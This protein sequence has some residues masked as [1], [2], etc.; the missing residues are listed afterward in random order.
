MNVDNKPAGVCDTDPWMLTSS[1][2]KVYFLRPDSGSLNLGDVCR[3]LGNL[4]RFTGAVSQFYSVA[5]HS[6]AVGR[7]VQEHLNEH[8]WEKDSKYWNQILAGLMHDAAEAYVN[9][10]SSPLKAAI[11]GKYDWIESGIRRKLFDRYRVPHELYN[12][13][14]KWADQQMCAIE[15]YYFMPQ[16]EDWPTPLEVVGAP[17][18]VFRDPN[19]AT[20]LMREELWH[21]FEMRNRC[22]VN[23]L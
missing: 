21:A 15:R 8:G 3:H 23:E 7:M 16:H 13:I 9:D 1:G 4:C 22:L 5:Q 2:Q 10:L 12:D 19:Q 11:H 17:M 6:V 20:I 18:P 14:V